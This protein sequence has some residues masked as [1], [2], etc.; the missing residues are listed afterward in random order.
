MD[1]KIGYTEY[2][3]VII[4][5]SELDYVRSYDGIAQG[6]LSSFNLSSFNLSS[7]NL[8]ALQALQRQRVIR[9]NQNLA[10]YNKGTDD[11]FRKFLAVNVSD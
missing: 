5:T 10:N 1:D 3:T 11:T 4:P 6:I 8:N 2:L 7:F 9:E